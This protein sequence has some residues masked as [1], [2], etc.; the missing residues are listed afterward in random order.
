LRCRTGAGGF[1]LLVVAD[2]GGNAESEDIAAD[3]E[4]D[5]AEVGGTG[6]MLADEEA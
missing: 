3:A 5:S 4:V 1:N 6:S 2:A